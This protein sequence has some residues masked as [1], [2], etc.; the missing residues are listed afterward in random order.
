MTSNVLIGTLNPTHSRTHYSVSYVVKGQ[1]TG[2]MRCLLPAPP[3]QCPTEHDHYY[4]LT[5]TAAD[6]YFRDSNASVSLYSGYRTMVRLW[7]DGRS[8]AYQ[9]LQWRKPLVAVTL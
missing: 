7:L 1:L 8:T 9:R 6:L 2:R 5:P 4:Q 3:V